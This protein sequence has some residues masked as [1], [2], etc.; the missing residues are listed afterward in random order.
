ML[1]KLF[2]ELVTSAVDIQN[3]LKTSEESGIFYYLIL[4]PQK[5]S[6]INPVA[7]TLQL[8]VMQR[9]VYPRETDDI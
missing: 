7:I 3:V 6:N 9:V 8:T 4:H 1:V 5:Y 2:I